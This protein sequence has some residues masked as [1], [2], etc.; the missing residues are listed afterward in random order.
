MAENKE[1]MLSTGK[2]ATKLG[3]SPA[4]IK[5]II[6]ELEIQ[7]DMK[8]GNCAYFGADAQKKIESKL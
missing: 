6:Q 8:K 4:K 7:P 3:V 2:V 5:K 1:E